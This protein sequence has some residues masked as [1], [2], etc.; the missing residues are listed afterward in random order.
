MRYIFTSKTYQVVSLLGLLLF[1]SAAV[2]QAQSL[3]TLTLLN[4]QT[5]QTLVGV[6]YQYG[7]MQGTSDA[8]GQIHLTFMPGET[9][10]L[11][12]VSYG[13]WQLTAD[14]LQNYLENGVYY[15][16]EAINTLYPV[17]VIA[18]HNNS[19]IN[20]SMTLDSRDKLA[21]DGGEVLKNVPF[22]SGIRKSGNYGFD[23]VMR[24]FKYEQL[25][26]VLNG[27][28]S[29]M[30]ACP[31]RMDPPT[32]QMAP[33]MM[34]KVEIYKGPHALRFGNSFGGT[35]NFIAAEPTF[36]NYLKPFGRLTGGYENNGNNLHSEAMAGFSAK[37][38]NVAIF[39]SLAQGKDYVDGDGIS[40]PS[41]F[42]RNS[43]GLSTGLKLSANQQLKI[44]VHRNLA[45]DVDFPALPMDLRKD[46]TWLMYASHKITIQNHALQQWNTSLYGTFVDHEMDNLL[47]E[48]EPRMLNADTKAKTRYIGFRTEGQ[49]N[50]SGK[51][52]FLGAD[53]NSEYAEGK[54]TRTFL[55]GSNM[56]NS[57]VD[58][59]WQE[60]S[61]T[62]S[63]VFGSYH[64]L[65]QSMHYIISS[66]LEF[67]QALLADADPAFAENYDE[68]TKLQ[69][70]PSLSV[71]GIYTINPTLS[72]GLWFGRAQRSG[73]LTE[74]YINYFP[75]GVDP[76]EMLGNP[77]LKPEVNNQLDVNIILT[78][79]H[80][81]LSLDVFAAY[82][83][84]YISSGIDT[85]LTPRMPT[86]PG[87]RQY[88]NIKDAFKTGFEVSWHQQWFTYLSQELN[89][90]FTY[91]QNRVLNEP[92]PEIAPFD[93]RYKLRG[94]FFNNCLI[95]EMIVRAVASQNR[96]SKEF[97]EIESP[98]FVLFD[99][100]VSYKLTKNMKF[101]GGVQNLFNVLYYEH[102][103]RPV[104]GTSAPIYAPGRNVF[105][106]FT[107]D[108]M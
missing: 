14:S 50:F 102:L 97:G 9:L 87:V 108:F 59:V 60:S 98:A 31:N 32:S 83:Q 64:W 35:I 23:P 57:V 53:A 19:I 106:S 75:V 33:N 76:Y 3:Q 15:R 69:W 105:V 8:Q 39:G 51:R 88:A 40:I 43:F 55:M 4:P 5:Q 100:Q 93:L 79:G 17:T 82:L 21:H 91:A 10:Q 52:L 107:L 84:N 47:K 44:S 86:S 2:L 11:S 99:A 89:L 1:L 96:I 62:K 56:G 49:W 70:N 30:A 36:T 28:Q 12:H 6:N 92:L 74:K 37:N 25:N 85:S 78:S 58:N 77:L 66:R 20:E 63:A 90:A 67:N 24:G 61:I 34:D 18:L 94:Q 16:S 81:H 68:T 54:R 71:G 65:H 38:V 95:P 80:T 101:I 41:G 104:S 103:S 26:I 7:T 46:D 48:L 73:S 27:A 13:K 22:V 45:K 29:A 42:L 72:A